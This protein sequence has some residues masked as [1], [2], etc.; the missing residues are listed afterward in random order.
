MNFNSYTYTYTANSQEYEGYLSELSILDADGEDYKIYDN[1]YISYPDSTD[2]N[3]K[4]T[5]Q[6]LYLKVNPT[7]KNILPRP[8]IEINYGDV[9]SV[10][11]GKIFK[12][13]N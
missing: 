2:G 13:L 11:F 8:R 3:N 5:S 4:I 9:R 10:L 12:T 1:F 7:N 6:Q